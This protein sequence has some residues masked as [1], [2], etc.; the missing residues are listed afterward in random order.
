MKALKHRNCEF[1]VWF[2]FLMSKS[3][4]LYSTISICKSIEWEEGKI[5]IFNRERDT[6]WRNCETNN[7]ELS[8]KGRDGDW[9]CRDVF[10]VWKN[11]VSEIRGVQ[12]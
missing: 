7:F 11:G 3:V 8:G 2:D 9:M 12:D 5:S 4:E 6:T 10:C 1:T